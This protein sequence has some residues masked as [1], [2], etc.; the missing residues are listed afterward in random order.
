MLNNSNKNQNIL[1]LNYF[2]ELLTEA[3]I[4]SFYLYEHL[5]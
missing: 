1:K 4:F 3:V 2:K 5:Y